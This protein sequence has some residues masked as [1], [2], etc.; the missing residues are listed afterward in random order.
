M[1]RQMRAIKSGRSCSAG[2]CNL[3]KISNVSVSKKRNRGRKYGTMQGMYHNNFGRYGGR[4]RRLQTYILSVFSSTNVTTSDSFSICRHYAPFANCAQIVPVP[5]KVASECK[6][7]SLPQCNQD[8]LSLTDAA[9]SAE[10][11]TRTVEFLFHLL[12]VTTN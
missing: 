10:A 11:R 3:R 6:G 5:T 12:I 2:F 4:G 7:P 8:P 9:E 1:L